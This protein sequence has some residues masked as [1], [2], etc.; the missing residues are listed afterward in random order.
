MS[1][2]NKV[3][4]VFKN[5]G[6]QSYQSTLIEMQSFTQKRHNATK[7]EVWFL[8]HEPVYTYGPRTKKDDIPLFANTP[9]VKTDRGGQLTFHGPGQLMVYL[10]FDLKRR[11]IKI[12]DFI[13][14]FEKTILDTIQ[15]YKGNAFLKKNE[16]GIF[17]EE[18][19]IVSFGLKITKGCTY[20]GAS[21]NI[22]MDM[23][24]WE[25]IIICGDRSNKVSDLRNLGVNLGVN[26]VSNDI[27]KN[28]LRSF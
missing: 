8:E 2:K 5:L 7:D 11:S 17:I 4:I 24:P 9:I 1:K 28:I 14:S 3:P 22:S 12:G 23:N 19:K 21:I 16:P 6:L 15:N 26:E 13:S 25:N 10:L 27:K 18:K 20:H